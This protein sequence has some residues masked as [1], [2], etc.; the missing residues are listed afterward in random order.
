MKNHPSSH[1]EDKEASGEV[2]NPILGDLWEAFDM[3][4]PTFTDCLGEKWGT[5]FLR[6]IQVVH[7]GVVDVRCVFVSLQAGKSEQSSSTPIEVSSYP[8]EKREGVQGDG[9]RGWSGQRWSYIHNI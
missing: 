1:S 7:P 9:Q 4:C 8:K 3:I 6:K 5:G 2:R